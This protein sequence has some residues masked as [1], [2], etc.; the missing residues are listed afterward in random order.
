MSDR[1]AAVDAAPELWRSLF[2]FN[3]YRLVLA[4]I[5]LMLAF[6]GGRAVGGVNRYPDLFMIAAIAFAALATVYFINISRATPEFATQIRLQTFLD[7]LLITTLIHASDGFESGYGALMVVSIAGVSLLD[8]RRSAIAFAAMGTL[9]VLGEAA[10][11][12]VSGFGN[13]FTLRGPGFLGLGLFCTALVV[14]HLAEKTRRSERLAS[15]HRAAMADLN[16]LNRQIVSLLPSGVVA[17]DRYARIIASNSRAQSLLGAGANP[18]GRQLSDVAPELYASLLRFTDNPDAAGGEELHFAGRTLTPRIRPLGSGYL[19]YL[20]D[21]SLEREAARNTRLAALGR[22]AAAIAHEI[23]N[24]LSAIYQSAQLLSE[25]PAITPEDQRITGII[26]NHSERIE[27]IVGAVL[28]VSRGDPGEPTRISLRP[29]LERFAETF[30]A[31]HHLPNDALAV[32]GED[33]EIYIDPYRLEQ[34]LTNLCENSLSHN[35]Q[36]DPEMIQL[37]VSTAADSNTP[38]LDVIDHGSGIDADDRRHLFEPFFST[39]SG[40]TGLG[41]YISRELCESG[42]ARLSHEADQPGTVFRITFYGNPP[43]GLQP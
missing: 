33:L 28:G 12:V 24:P 8:Q 34:V 36:H 21:M 5:L 42:D 37:K 3:I 1:S 29:W 16:E 30:T 18:D 43:A 38:V 2:Y 7:L 31:Q 40:G 41:L 23:R 9:L 19:L 4:A 17:I 13:A 27:R 25:S 26:R 11:G 32:T 14:S 15:Q 35:E 10:V 39:R 20:E 6:T 22:L